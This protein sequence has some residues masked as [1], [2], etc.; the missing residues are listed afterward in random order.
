MTWWLPFALALATI[1][2]PE[3]PAA[4]KGDAQ[5]LAAWQA[6]REG[7][8]LGARRAAA[9]LLLDRLASIP[10][11]ER[12]PFLL[13][14][15]GAGILHA[16]LEPAFRLICTERPETREEVRALLLDGR[17]ED[18]V[19]ERGVLAAVGWLAF[20]SE[21]EVEALA[22]AMMRSELRPA[23]AEAL[24]RVTGHEFATF[25]AFT[26][27]WTSAK[28]QTRAQW[29]ANA[30]EAQRARSLQH[31]ILLLEREPAWGIIAAR[32]PSPAVRRLAYEALARLEPPP[33]LPPDSEPAGVLSTAFATER[34]PELRLL[35]VGLVARFLQGEPAGLLLEQALASPHATERLRAV[36]QLGALRD[37]AA[38]WDRLTRELLRVYP[39]DGAPREPSDFRN[40]LW[41][42]LNLSLASDPSFAPAP[43][44]HLIGLLLTVLE[45]LEP[46]AAVRAREY[47]LLARFP[48][49]ILR[50]RLLAHAMDVARLAQ[51]RAA[52]LESATVMFLR[53]GQTL[54]LR[55]ALPSLLADAAATV[56]GRAIRSLTRLGEAGDLEL[57]AAR[58]AIETEPP[59]LSELMKALREKPLP[60]LLAPLLAFEPPPELHTEHVR[61]LQ[62]LIGND[63]SA[64][65]R[66]V[67]QLS[68]RA[69][70][71]G[72]Y[73][74]AYGFTREG[75]AAEVLARHDRMLARTQ[76]EWLLKAGVGGADAARAADALGFLAD[77]ERR[78]PTE[79]EWPQ[80]QA[81]LAFLLG[82]TDAA[83][84]ATE[85]LLAL[86]A[87]VP[88]PLRWELALRVARAAA[89]A[90]LYE[91]G[92]KLLSG[93]GEP[94]EEFAAAASEVRALFPPPVEPPAPE[95]VPEQKAAVG[96]PE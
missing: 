54:E 67:T 1:G 96:T 21:T 23:A 86:E 8:D 19:R 71:D 68:A 59:L 69:R 41:S 27:W 45:G 38:A 26:T 22:A 47:A 51:D 12:L 14:C 31:W 77:L 35:L 65:E 49:K 7:S 62:A 33:G 25:D 57:L 53:A 4:L 40:A 2:E 48:Q 61:A 16:D 63:F 64:L 10:A 75:M 89:A 83:L 79:P 17:H 76:A 52:A 73:A 46:E 95:P 20:D 29:L 36:E 58:L 18:L 72:A 74:L 82:R 78:W 44:A 50:D 60:T 43:E 42:A 34:D 6:A 91:R 28:T 15:Q 93:L 30:M 37:R 92:W 88:N 9:T 80:L 85:R 11:V 94:P 84:G 39:L 13:D 90:G 81:E 55:A 70:A 87:A 5:V 24:R 32:D 3:L 56:R 66:A